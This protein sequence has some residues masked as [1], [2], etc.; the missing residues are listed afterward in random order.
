MGIQMAFTERLLAGAA[1]SGTL[2]RPSAIWRDR[3][4]NCSQSTRKKLPRADSRLP[5]KDRR[6]APE[7][8]ALGL[9]KTSIYNT[10]AEAGQTGRCEIKRTSPVSRRERKRDADAKR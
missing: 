9:H 1:D 6:S 8:G 7:D 5:Q 10:L 4:A 3:R 2:F